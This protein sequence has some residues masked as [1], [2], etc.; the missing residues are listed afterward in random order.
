MGTG[1]SFIHGAEES[2]APMH[3]S[4]AWPLSYPSSQSSTNKRIMPKVKT[5]HKPM[6][7]TILRILILTVIL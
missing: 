1:E 7:G 6:E 3:K 2:H 4:A 5:R